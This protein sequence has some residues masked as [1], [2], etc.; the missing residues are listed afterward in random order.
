M[1]PAPN[2]K[3]TPKQPT[4]S[5]E[6]NLVA[7]SSSSTTTVQV[8]PR[9]GNDVLKQYQLESLKQLYVECFGRPMP[10]PISAELLRD[11]YAETPSA[12]R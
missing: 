9:N 6:N 4:T 3:R 12:Y 11:L 7:A 2:N 10:A 1:T 8:F 5:S